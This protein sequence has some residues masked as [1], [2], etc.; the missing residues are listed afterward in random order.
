MTTLS[1]SESASQVALLH[2]GLAGQTTTPTRLQQDQVLANMFRLRKVDAAKI[3]HPRNDVALYAS[4]LTVS[5]PL[6]PR[7]GI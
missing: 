3:S 4:S 7:P 5:A 1:L 6:V 2:S